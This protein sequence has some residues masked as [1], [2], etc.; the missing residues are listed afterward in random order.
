KSGA[1]VQAEK[2]DVSKT[3]LLSVFGSKGTQKELDKSYSGA[4][5]L[6]GMAGQATG[7]AGFDE[8]RAGDNLGGRLKNVGAGGKGTQT[9]GISGPGTSGKG[10]GTYGGGTGGIGQKGRVDL[11]VGD[12]EAEFSGTIDKD[13]IRRVIRDNKRLFENCYNQALRRDS[14]L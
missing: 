14:G 8:D 13:A 4:G 1:N 10:T 7:S 12:S 5:E 11:N 2:K 3:G 9:Y 6:V